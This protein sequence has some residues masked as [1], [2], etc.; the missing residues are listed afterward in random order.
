MAVTDG[1]ITFPASIGEV[2][3]LLGEDTRDLGR[4][5]VSE[6]INKY[7]R[8]KP[9]YAGG[10]WRLTDA[11]RIAANNGLAIPRY[12]T[13]SALREA[14]LGGAIEWAYN[15]PTNRF[16]LTDFERYNHF[17]DWTLTG[18]GETIFNGYVLIGSDDG[19]IYSGTTI[20][21]WVDYED[22][23]QSYTPLLYP[24]DWNE[25]SNDNLRALRLGLVLIN[26]TTA[27]IWFRGASG[28]LAEGFVGLTATIPTAVS[29]YTTWKI[30]PVLTDRITD[31]FVDSDASGIYI[32]IEGKYYSCLKL[33]EDPN[34]SLHYTADGVAL[35]NEI[36]LTVTLRNNT[37]SPIHVQDLY[38]VIS[39]EGAYD[40]SWGIVEM[41]ASTWL[42]EN[43]LDPIL[44]APGGA[45]LDGSDKICQRF[46]KLIDA[47]RAQVGSATVP[48]FSSVQFT[49]SIPA[50]GDDYGRYDDYTYTAFLTNDTKSGYDVTEFEVSITDK[51]A[52]CFANGYWDNLSPWTNDLGWKNNV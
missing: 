40:S 48:A 45:I 27:E 21:F 17:D 32:P 20:S 37:I 4:L 46:Y 23:D 30:I 10:F 24:S 42:T 25:T 34:A 8:Y 28:T 35:E 43:K 18:D 31:Y 11:E 33:A 12:G 2:A 7:A 5:C 6:R 22:P 50:L 41:A 15:R 1:K 19:N 49:F 13:L 39:S 51:T 14:V 38:L 29:N 44:P 26:E 9:I 47:L 16:R 36:E 3:E 52:S